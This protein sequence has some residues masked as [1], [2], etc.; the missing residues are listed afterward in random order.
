M[1]RR[2]APP[3]LALRR[4]RREGGEH[5]TIAQARSTA[6]R[7]CLWMK[8]APILQ[9]FSGFH[10]S[11]HRCGRRRCR[12]RSRQRRS[13]LSSDFEIRPRA[14]TT[15]EN[16]GSRAGRLY[17]PL[18][19]PSHLETRRRETHLPTERSSPEAASRVPSADVLAR[20]PRDPQAASR[21]RAQA[22]LRL[23]RPP[24][25]RRNRLSRSQDFDTVYRR[26]RSA[27]TPLPRPALVPARRRRGRRAAARARGPALGRLGGRAEPR[28]AAAARGVARAPSDRFR[29]ARTTC[30]PLA[31]VSPSRPR[32]AGRTGSSPRSP[33]CSRRLAREVRRHRPRARVALDVRAPHARRDVQVP[34]ELLAVRDRRAP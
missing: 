15:V 13:R 28:E 20:R 17:S 18:P 14:A 26:G 1:S 30:S 8:I 22:P 33:T 24:V 31:R 10:T 5:S 7:R 4:G 32:R 9:G 27:S 21:A 16:L 34:P 23:R 2:G 12:C 29:R 3:V 6:L 25:Q 11:F 19:D